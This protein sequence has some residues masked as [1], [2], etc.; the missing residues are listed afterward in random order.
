[1][2]NLLQYGGHT[3]SL[4]PSTAGH[5]ANVYDFAN[6]YQQAQLDTSSST[7]PYGN[8]TQAA[9]AAA[10]VAQQAASNPANVNY[11]YAALAQQAIAAGAPSLAA[12]A[13]QQ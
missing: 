13:Y 2:P 12:S 9:V 6:Q 1:M 10:V 5:Y 8:S 3:T 11:A 4:S 7:F